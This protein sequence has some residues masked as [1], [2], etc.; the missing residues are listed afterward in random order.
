MFKI[1]SDLNSCD[2]LF[3]IFIY[4]VFLKK[5]LYANVAILNVKLYFLL[6]F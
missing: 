1:H 6:L 2:F 5:K 3:L 4:L